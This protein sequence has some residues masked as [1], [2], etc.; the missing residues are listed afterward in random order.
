[1]KWAIRNGLGRY[2]MGWS[3]ENGCSF[4]EWSARLDRS[5]L[6]STETD[7]QCLIRAFRLT[8]PGA[9]DLSIPVNQLSVVSIPNWGE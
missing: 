1:M 6:Y 5:C 9:D 8:V 7:A 2:L 4:V 3:V